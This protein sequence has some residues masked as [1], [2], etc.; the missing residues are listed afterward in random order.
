LIDHYNVVAGH[1]AGVSRVNEADLYYLQSR[2]IDKVNAEHLMTLAFIKP[3]VDL[4]TDEE[5]KSFVEE[6]IEVIIF[7]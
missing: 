2:G 3:L 7:G 1:A 5:V 4:I 6:Q